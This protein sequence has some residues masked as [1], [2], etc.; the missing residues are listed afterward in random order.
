MC[1]HCHSTAVFV[2]VV[3]SVSSSSLLFVVFVDCCCYC[4]S[5]FFFALLFAVCVLLEH[6]TKIRKCILMQIFL[7]CG[8]MGEHLHKQFTPICRMQNATHCVE[9][10]R[11]IQLQSHTTLDFAETQM[12]NKIR[13]ASKTRR[14][15]T[16][17]KKKKTLPMSV[18]DNEKVINI[19]MPQTKWSAENKNEAKCATTTTAWTSEGR[20]KN[21][22]KT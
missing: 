19:V 7:D 1:W 21:I 20:K 13:N 3:I 14:K 15:K 16:N 9:A 22:Q 11:A 4:W 5:F 18:E 6:R 8:G 10:F 12:Y 2:L 17:K